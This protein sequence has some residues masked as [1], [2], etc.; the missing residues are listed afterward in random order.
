MKSL[1]VLLLPLIVHAQ[2]PPAE[3]Q[4]T[5]GEVIEDTAEKAVT[6]TKKVL[7]AAKDHRAD[8]RF[9]ITGNYSYIDLLIPSKIGFTAGYVTSAANTFELDYMRA[10]L[11]FGWMGLD[12]GSLTEE[13]IALLWR[14]FNKRNSF[15][16]QSGIHYNKFRVHLGNDLLA[17]VTANPGFDFTFM[18]FETLGLSWGLGNRWQTK[19]G[20]VWGFDWFQIH[21]PLVK[22]NEKTPYL[23][24]ATNAEDRED[25]EDASRVIRNFPRLVALKLQLGFSF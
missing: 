4:K 22:L 25:A 19:S 1:L 24:A 10:S 12:I 2:T 14:S 3:E 6:E 7:S 13:R 16:F 9:V 11:G 15:N 17:R 23:A 18:E 21:V 8:S 5:A 20:F